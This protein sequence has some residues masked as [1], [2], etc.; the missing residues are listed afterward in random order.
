MRSTVKAS[1]VIRRVSQRS[2]LAHPPSRARQ[3][4]TQVAP[5]TLFAAMFTLHSSATS[6]RSS[7]T[8]QQL[9]HSNSN[10]LNAQQGSTVFENL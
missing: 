4:S 1:S 10:P 5:A 7:A 6:Q 8:S 3:Y 9:C 2:L